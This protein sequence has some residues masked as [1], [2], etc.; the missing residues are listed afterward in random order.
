MTFKVAICGLKIKI[1]LKV[2]LQ[3][4]TRVQMLEIRGKMC[5]QLVK[6]LMSKLKE[7]SQ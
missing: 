3:V 2:N 1:C 5:C 6:K 4:S 7:S